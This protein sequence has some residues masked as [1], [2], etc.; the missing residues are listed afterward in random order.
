MNQLGPLIDTL[1][2]RHG[3]VAAA[4]AWLAS[5]RVFLKLC[6]PQLNQ[7]FTETLLWVH[8]SPMLDDDRFVLRLLANPFYRIAAFLTDYLLSVKLPTLAQFRA[9]EQHAEDNQPHLL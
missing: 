4:F 8:D 9:H 2:A 6:S 7:F 1:S 5:A 3:W